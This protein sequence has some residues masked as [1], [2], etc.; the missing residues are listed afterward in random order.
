MV[1][2][3]KE[4]EFLNKGLFKKISIYE[5]NLQKLIDKK[6]E[7]DNLQKL[8]NEELP[9]SYNNSTFEEQKDYLKQL[10]SEAKLQYFELLNK[11]K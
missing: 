9:E 2:N 11:Y 10:Q 1:N 8:I 6:K 4:Y 3:G 5:N 7:L